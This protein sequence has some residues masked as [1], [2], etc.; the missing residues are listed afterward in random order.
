VPGVRGPRKVQHVSLLLGRPPRPA[1][2]CFSPPAPSRVVTP[3]SSHGDAPQLIVLDQD[4]LQPFGHLCE[5]RIGRIVDPGVGE[6]AAVGSLI[7]G[8]RAEDHPSFS[9]EIHCKDLAVHYQT[10]PVVHTVAGVRG[11]LEVQMSAA[12]AALCHPRV[13]RAIS[14]VQHL[15]ELHTVGLVRV[16]ITIVN[17]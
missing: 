16:S 5:L 9:S 8:G 11:E 7:C 14:Q 15:E 13:D 12:F 6:G 3:G 10:C 2:S 4:P 17:V 1:T